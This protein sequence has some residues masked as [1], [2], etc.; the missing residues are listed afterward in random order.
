MN[1]TI[2]DKVPNILNRNSCD[3]YI[4]LFVRVKYKWG[5]INMKT[6]KGKLILQALALL[7][8][9]C[10][11]LGG[12]SIKV[13]TDTVSKDI[14][15][16]LSKAADDA[17]RF[18]SLKLDTEITILKQIAG[19]TRISDPANPM[20]DRQ[21]ALKSD[22]ERNGYTR[23]AFVDLKGMAYYSDGSSKDL[24]DRDYVKI[25]LGGSD[26]ISDTIVSKV[27]GSVVMAF[28]VPVKF[29]DQIAGALVAIRPGEYIG[30]DI[31]S[32]NVGGT[33]YAF[34]VSK[35]GTL[36]AHIKPELVTEQYNFFEA[37]TK[38]PKLDRLAN[39]VKE[40]TSGKSGVS[41]YWFDGIEKVIGYAPVEGTD[42]GI[43]VTISY[44]EIMAPVKSLQ[45]IILVV[46][47]VV[48]C[49]AVILFWVI[50]NSIGVPIIQAVEHA[51]VLAS[52]DY[53]MN[54][55]AEFLKRKDEIGQLARAFDEVTMS[56]RQL[57]G[58]VINLSQQL[59]AS[60][61]EISA[62]SD[63]VLQ[64]S[65]E[66]SSTVEEIAQG[67]TDQAQETEK[68]AHQAAELGTLID[69]STVRIEGLQKSSKIIQERVNEGLESVNLLI[70]KANETKSATESIAAVIQS[71]DAS[72]RKIGDASRFIS[73][74]SDQ[75]NL[76]ALNAAIEAARA[77]EHGRGFA[78]VAEEI[79]KLAEQS[80]ESTKAIDTIVNELLKNSQESVKTASSVAE[81]IEQQLRSV[82]D[83]EKKYREIS[84][85]VDDSLGLIGELSKESHN[86]DRNKEKIIEAI[87]GLSAI[88][89][90]NAASTEEVSASLHVQSDSV[91]EVTQANRALAEMATELAQE[92]SKFKV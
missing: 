68:G 15:T 60:S 82:T 50:G 9:V 2:F 85:A 13:S 35:E 14:D 36:Q 5:G 39:V 24:S 56:S 16:M 58:K 53:S 49:V 75:T 87:S 44:D 26:S 90:E 55:P 1:P 47:G 73:N 19:R 27:D 38:E 20:P 4:E 89:E 92:A 45:S 72:S 86:M 84:E 48:L 40:M 74:I 37:A 70:D 17:A 66:I 78:V 69:N 31:T 91:Q 62:I 22:L 34:L 76:L 10:T 59:A 71:T 7:L 41:H 88:A 28:A 64:S 83:A 61:E 29:N 42:W 63:Q 79:R 6:I 43:G 32:V 80:T 25:A 51:K 52:G 46:T 67:A 8:V 65:K 81:A 18:T 77:G 54:A 11:I 57:I 30:K 3:K 33:S 21:A 12:V 23:L